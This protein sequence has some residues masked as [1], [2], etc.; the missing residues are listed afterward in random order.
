MLK[1]AEGA[2]SEPMFT[3]PPPTCPGQTALFS[4]KTHDD[5]R[6]HRSVWVVSEATAP[7]GGCPLVH[8]AWPDDSVGCGSFTGH[9]AGEIP[10]NCFHTELSVTATLALN[11]TSVA[12][13]FADGGPPDLIGST[14]LLVIGNI[15]LFTVV[16]SVLCCANE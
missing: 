15:H 3:A 1:T 7:Y 6:I 11:A 9:S 8:Y 2:C 16:S 10:G 13:Y 5:T 12:C 4:C 14:T